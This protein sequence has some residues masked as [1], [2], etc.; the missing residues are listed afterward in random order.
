VR[1]GLY[2]PPR[3]GEVAGRFHHEMFDP[4]KHVGMVHPLTE[5]NMSPVLTEHFLFTRSSQN[6]QVV[7]GTNGVTRYVVKYI[8]K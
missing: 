3:D 4:H 2:T 8:V 1:A 5:E 6:M 7:K